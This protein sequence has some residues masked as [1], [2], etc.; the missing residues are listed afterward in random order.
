MIGRLN[1]VAIAVR[2]I[3][4]ASAIYRDM[5]G[6]EISVPTLDGKVKLRIPAG[7]EHGQQ[8]RVRGRGRTRGNQERH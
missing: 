5:L 8:L 7:I 3:T 6:A 2:N 1:H 4:K